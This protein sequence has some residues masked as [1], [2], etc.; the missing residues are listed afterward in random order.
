M[1]KKFECISHIERMLDRE[2]GKHA[3]C[4]KPSIDTVYKVNKVVKNGRV[5]SE[6]ERTELDPREK[7]EGYKVS[8]F[9]IEMLQTTGAIANIHPITLDGGSM[10][11]TDSLVASLDSLDSINVEEK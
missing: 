2:K 5:C 1:G 8:D 3:R 9:S 11:M 4:A 6:L 7:F 10:S